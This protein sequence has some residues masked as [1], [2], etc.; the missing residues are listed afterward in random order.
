[1]TGEELIDA[2]TAD[3]LAAGLPPDP[4]VRIAALHDIVRARWSTMSPEQ[5]ADVTADLQDEGERPP[6]A[7]DPEPALQDRS[8]LD[9][10]AVTSL[11]NVIRERIPELSVPEV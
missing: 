8:E 3:Y 6:L 7:G 10:Q 5:R 11:V 4:T 1:M 2:V 9:E